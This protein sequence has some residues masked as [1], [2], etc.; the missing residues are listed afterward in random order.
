MRARIIQLSQS[1]LSYR[2]IADYVDCVP[3]TVSNWIARWIE[4]PPKKKRELKAWLEDLPR[5]GAPC[6]FNIDQ[7]AQVIALAC[8]KPED[9]GLPITTWT[10]EELRQVAIEEKIVELEAAAFGI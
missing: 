2:K 6:R 9:Y 10:S 8:E 3:T 7:R 5:S 1:D 4:S